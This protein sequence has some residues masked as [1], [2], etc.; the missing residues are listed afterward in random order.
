MAGVQLPA[1]AGELQVRCPSSQRAQECC[2][3][4]QKRW[5]RLKSLCFPWEATTSSGRQSTRAAGSTPRVCRE[6]AEARAAA[7]GQ[8][9]DSVLNTELQGLDSD[10]E[11]RRYFP[12]LH[13]Q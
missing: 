3:A 12:S 2:R 1:P 13:A 5:R 10:A 4:L 9:L 8:T 6:F 11:A 7:L